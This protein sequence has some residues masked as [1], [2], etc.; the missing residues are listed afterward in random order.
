V[1]LIPKTQDSF[2]RKRPRPILPVRGAAEL[3]CECEAGLVPATK[4]G[5]HEL[6]RH[7]VEAIARDHVHR[8]LVPVGVDLAGAVGV[9]LRAGD[10]LLAQVELEPVLPSERHGGVVVH[11]PRQALAGLDRELGHGDVGADPGELRA[12]EHEELVQT[13]D[14]HRLGLG[15]AVVVHQREQLVRHVALVPP[16]VAIVGLRTLGGAELVDDAVDLPDEPVDLAQ[17]VHEVLVHRRPFPLQIRLVL[18][19]RQLAQL[20]Q[21]LGGVPVQLV[22]PRLGPVCGRVLDDVEVRRGRAGET[23]R[24]HRR[25]QE[26]EQ[27]GSQPDTASR[28]PLSADLHWVP[29]VLEVELCAYSAGNEKTKSPSSINLFPS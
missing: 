23:P 29:S 15:R 7:E 21:R 14:G 1:V 27:H 22:H 19:G 24:P 9:D 3:T 17:P 25:D 12:F 11:V 6:A 5:R 16:A 2:E 26:Q 10:V 28:E 4:G 8:D 20:A 13:P 18:V